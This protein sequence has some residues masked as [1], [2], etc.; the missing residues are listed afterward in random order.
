MQGKASPRVAIEFQFAA[1][2]WN[3]G[4]Y[5]IAAAI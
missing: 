2:R 4:R 3:V 5:N 1:A